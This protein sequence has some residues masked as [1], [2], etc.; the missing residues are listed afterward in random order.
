MTA[1][2]LPPLPSTVA[3]PQYI[4][5][6]AVEYKFRETSWPGK[7]NAKKAGAFGVHKVQKSKVSKSQRRV[8]SW[9][10]SAKL[11]LMN[12][13]FAQKA[14]VS[15]VDDDRPMPIESSSFIPGSSLWWEN[16]V[17]IGDGCARALAVGIWAYLAWE[18]A[19]NLFHFVCTCRVLKYVG[20]ARE[21]V[22][23]L[24]RIGLGKSWRL[25]V[26]GA[27]CMIQLLRSLCAQGWDPHR[28]LEMVISGKS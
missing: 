10:I 19:N 17:K 25:Y 23:N 14:C 28:A 6:G 27:Y 3:L 20:V 15:P 22:R 13:R 26:E 21:T 1:P 4:P 8:P 7:K 24:F 9:Q 16:L 12:M 2:A 18:M 11:I 5:T